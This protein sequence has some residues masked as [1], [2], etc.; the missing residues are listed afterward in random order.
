MSS[1]AQIERRTA[2]GAPLELRDAETDHGTLAGYG[3][4]FNTKS[5]DLGGYKETISVGAVDLQKVRDV[6]FLVAHDDALL[7]GRT[8]NDTL[9]LAVDERGVSFTLTLPD[10][11][12]AHDTRELVRL[13]TLDG[14]SF[15][16]RTIADEWSPDRRS[17]TVTKLELLEL[18]A[19]S[20]PAYEATHVEAREVEEARICTRSAFATYHARRQAAAADRLAP[21]RRGLVLERWRADLALAAHPR[22]G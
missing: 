22:R 15:G 5:V 7:L 14:M 8:K 3:L 4:L 18:S 1:Q 9:R 19:V 21:Y 16:F 11:A 17:R 12:L 20:F 10:T 6:K 13:G 2:I